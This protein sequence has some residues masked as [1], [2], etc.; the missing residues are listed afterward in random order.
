MPDDADID[1][2]A[3]EPRR[4]LIQ[5]LSRGLAVI[6]AF[7]RSAPSMTLSE[8][9]H[10]TALSRAVARRFLLTLVRDGY[11]TTDGKHFR[12]AP[13]VLDLGYA[14]LTSFDVWAV[15]QPMMAQVVAR[16]GETCSAAV[17]DGAEIVYVARVAAGR[18]MQVG[19]NVGSRL[20]AFCSAMGRVLLAGLPPERRDALLAAAPRPAFTDRTLTDLT[21]VRAAIAQ[22]GAQGYAVVDQELEIGLRSLAVP[23]R[24]R[25]G[26]V[27][28]AMNI[29][30]H[31]NRG[32]LAD[33]VAAYLPALQDAAAQIAEMVN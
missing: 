17:L 24:S 6:R 7:D 13:K 9:A 25:A 8:V 31:T 1:A 26:E 20:P 33:I 19:L 11:A 21:A 3:G 32:T 14:F 28:A 10:R 27:R 22:A 18:I 5:S 2:P 4:D 23:I 16:T 30:L 15:A 12:L 29:S